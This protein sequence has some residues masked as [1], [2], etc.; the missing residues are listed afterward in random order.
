MHIQEKTTEY[1]AI[2]C[3]L[4]LLTSTVLLYR[5]TKECQVL[6]Q[7]VNVQTANSTTLQKIISRNMKAIIY[8]DHT[9]LNENIFLNTYI[10][11]K[12][13]SIPIKNVQDKNILFVPKQ[14]CNVCYD[15]VYDALLYARDSLNY[16][17]ITITEKEKYNEVRNILHDMGFKASIYCFDTQSF[18][19]STSIE[20]APFFSYVDKHL[21]CCHSFIPLPNY[22]EYSYLYLRTIIEKYGEK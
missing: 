4:L 17:V 13:D 21:K 22:P 19:Q 2:I 14:S 20:Y 8:F 3:I 16:D 9:Q 7:K 15:E 1:L 12:K 6:E 11:G 5:K 18:W 10:N